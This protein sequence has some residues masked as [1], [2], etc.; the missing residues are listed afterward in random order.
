MSA[1][2]EDAI[3]TT[4]FSVQPSKSPSG[5]IIKPLSG[6]DRESNETL[7]CI[8]L[9]GTQ[10][11]TLAKVKFLLAEEAQQEWQNLSMTSLNIDDPKE[12]ELTLFKS[13]QDGKGFTMKFL[14]RKGEDLEPGVVIEDFKFSSQNSQDGEV[15]LSEDPRLGTVRPPN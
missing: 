4:K 14:N 9:A 11:N 5:W 10:V 12:V 8:A 6:N 7:D 1:S 3:Y 13:I 15:Y 2:D